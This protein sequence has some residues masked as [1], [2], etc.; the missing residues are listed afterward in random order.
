VNGKIAPEN[1]KLIG[2]AEPIRL[3]QRG[4]IEGSSLVP[5]LRAPQLVSACGFSCPWRLSLDK[6]LRLR[7]KGIE[8]QLPARRGALGLMDREFPEPRW[9]VARDAGGRSPVNNLVRH[10]QG[11][12]PGPIG[13]KDPTREDLAAARPGVRGQGSAARRRN[14][15]FF[16]DKRNPRRQEPWPREAGGAGNAGDGQLNGCGRASSSSQ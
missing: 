6:K 15:M 1:R 3:F 16:A 7:S 8:R 5:D 12:P 4:S 9:C 10:D 11:G 2:V 14:S 13:R